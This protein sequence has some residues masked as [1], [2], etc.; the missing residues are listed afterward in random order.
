M[1]SLPDIIRL[2]KLSRMR[3]AGNVACMHIGFWWESQKKRLQGRPMCRL[4]DNIKMDLREIEWGGLD[5]ISLPQDR[6]QLQAVLN[7][8]INLWVP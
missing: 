7:M 6:S 8:L 4:E 1:Y 3:W 5:W 2:I